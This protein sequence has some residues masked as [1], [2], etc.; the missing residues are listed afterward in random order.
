MKHNWTADWS[1]LVVNKPSCVACPVLTGVIGRKNP[2]LD[3]LLRNI[4]DICVS[5]AD[6][7]DFSKEIKSCN[8]EFYIVFMF[9]SV[10]Q[11]ITWICSVRLYIIK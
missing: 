7:L 2:Q 3:V 5:G 11:I 1:R 4:T 9:L 8:F 10:L 6:E